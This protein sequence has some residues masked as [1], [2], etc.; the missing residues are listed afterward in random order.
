[1]RMRRPWTPRVVDGHRVG[2]SDT[3][4]GQPS[5]TN[6]VPPALAMTTPF[7]VPGIASRLRCTKPRDWDGDDPY[8]IAHNRRALY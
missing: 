2:A 8:Q 1:M 3:A 5:G 4:I 7:G 6:A